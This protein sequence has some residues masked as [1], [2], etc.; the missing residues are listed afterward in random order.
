MDRRKCVICLKKIDFGRD[1]YVKLIDYQGKKSISHC[2]YHLDCWQNRFV[3]TQ[4]KIQEQANK[5]FNQ[6]SAMLPDLKEKICIK[7]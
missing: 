1:K 4:E 5:W 2:F 7:E 6:L 3:I